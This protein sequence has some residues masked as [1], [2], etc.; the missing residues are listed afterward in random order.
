MNT[1]RKA[2]TLAK[3]QRYISAFAF[4]LR[5]CVKFYVSHKPLVL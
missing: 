5:L 2:A 4:G 3:P 1:S